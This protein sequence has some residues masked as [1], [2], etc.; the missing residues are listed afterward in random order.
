MRKRRTHKPCLFNLY[1]AGELLERDLAGDAVD[2]EH[3]LLGVRP[4]AALEHC[5][6]HP[7][8][9]WW[10]LVELSWESIQGWG[11]GTLAVQYEFGSSSSSDNQ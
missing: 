5:V 2:D 7:R 9:I 4:L 10:S 3:A 6:R 8:A 11:I 1:I